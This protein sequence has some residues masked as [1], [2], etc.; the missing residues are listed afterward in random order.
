MKLFQ[1]ENINADI[2]F[3]FKTKTSN[4][5]SFAGPLKYLKISGLSLINIDEANFKL[6]RLKNEEIYIGS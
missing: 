4:D 1:I 5:I 3:I 6:K 2:S